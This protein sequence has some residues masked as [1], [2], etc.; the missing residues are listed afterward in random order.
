MSLDLDSLLG[1]FEEIEF[2]GDGNEEVPSS[3]DDVLSEMVVLQERAAKAGFRSSQASE[4]ASERVHELAQ[5]FEEL[6]ARR[7]ADLSEARRRVGELLDER[8]RLIRAL[9]EVGDLL[10]SAGR[11]LASN[12]AS[13]ASDAVALLFRELRKV[14]SRCGLETTAALGEPFDPEFHELVDR[15]AES[16]LDEDSIAEVVKQ[17]YRFRGEVVRIAKVVVAA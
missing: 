1:D 14:L 3:F 4:L 10:D 2:G 12:D 7:E 16:E 15:D 11:A 5:Q 17:G 8:K 13:S 9:T 6:V